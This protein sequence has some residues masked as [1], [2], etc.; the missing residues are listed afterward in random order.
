MDC[1]EAK[2]L[3]GLY[4]AGSLALEVSQD[5][6]AHMQD[7]PTCKVERAVTEETYGMLPFALQGPPP[8]E[9]ARRALMAR[10]EKE[11]REMEPAS[12][13][14]W[15]TFLRHPAPAYLLL[16]LVVILMSVAGLRQKERLVTARAEI[17][18]LRSQ[19]SLTQAQLALLQ[20]SDT[21]VLK[22]TG[23]AVHPDATGKLFWNKSRNIWLVYMAHLPPPPPGKIYELWFLTKSAPVRAGLF[24]SDLNGNGFVQVSIPVGVEP[25]KAGVTLEPEAGVSAPTGA[26]YLLSE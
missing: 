14:S 19:I 10:L 6:E 5:L 11:A 15:W 20:G 26:L 7:C 22:L 12:P 3:M 24:V 21:T 9:S 1:K 25:I 16:A 18:R 8:P 4:V 2:E 23:Q 13:W 17:E